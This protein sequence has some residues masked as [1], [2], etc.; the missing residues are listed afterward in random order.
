MSDPSR[1]TILYGTAGLLALSAGCLDET[2]A[3]DGDNE[4]DDGDLG[5]DGS[6]DDDSDPESTTDE[7][8]ET[9]ETVSFSHSGVLEEP[10]V[11]LFV[12][13]DRTESWLDDREFD[14][15]TLAEFVDETLFEESA[16]FALEAEAPRLDYELDLETVTVEQEDDSD[17]QLVVE[18][19][20]RETSAE[21]DS[22]GGTQV[23][24]VGQLVRATFES[25]PVTS[26]S[27]T[28]VDS[29]GQEH[30]VGVAADSESES[31]SDANQNDES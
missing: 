20:V 6:D 23:I 19:A 11:T 24:T 1:R 18:A 8:D 21:S 22:V 12:S 2:G 26:A 14:D 7:T 28:I 16:L 15:E 25:E 13:A 29:D 9:P 17:P 5:A 10:D 27:V 3:D 4:D 30:S 31:A